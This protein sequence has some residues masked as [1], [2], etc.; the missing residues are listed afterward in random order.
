MKDVPTC[1]VYMG[2]NNH[3]IGLTDTVLYKADSVSCVAIGWLCTIKKNERFM[4]LIDF[5]LQNIIF[6]S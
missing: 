2:R 1:P 5:F 4:C 3:F 6:V